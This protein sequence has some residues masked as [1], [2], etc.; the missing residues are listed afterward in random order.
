MRAVRVISLGAGRAAACAPARRAV[1]VN[2]APRVSPATM[3]FSTSA[4]EEEEK[5][6]ENSA[7]EPAVVPDFDYY[8]VKPGIQGPATAI[9][10][11]RSFGH[12]L[13]NWLGRV[14][15]KGPREALFSIAKYSDLRTGTVVGVDSRGNKYMEDLT[16][17]HPRHRWV[18]F[19]ENPVMSTHAF[20]DPTSIS[21]L[22][23]SWLHHTTDLTGEQVE[24]QYW[25][26]WA[27]KD[28]EPSK[29]GTADAYAADAYL[30]N[31]K[32]RE[33]MEE[34]NQKQWD[35]CDPNTPVTGPE[36]I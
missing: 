32:S 14:A 22:W 23:H 34:R 33:V 27:A 5:A 9:D 7:P 11:G 36:A 6:S 3:W 13:K 4:E 8:K 2:P 25:K 17:A 12:N 18:E 24:A 28:A 1:A 31:E 26:N 15:R 21:P 29:T 30:L 10:E 19:K 35:S 16:S 20:M